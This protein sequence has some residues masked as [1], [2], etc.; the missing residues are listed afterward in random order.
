MFTKK[1]KNKKTK[2]FVKFRN[3]N[4]NL[5]FNKLCTRELTSVKIMEYIIDISINW[6]QIQACMNL[7]RAKENVCVTYMIL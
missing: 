4:K 1:L 3:T 6:L 2:S 5:K 7:G